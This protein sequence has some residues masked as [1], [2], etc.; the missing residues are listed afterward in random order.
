MRLGFSNGFKIIDQDYNPKNW[1]LLFFGL[2][3][4]VNLFLVGN[5]Y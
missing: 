2:F 5:N 4:L 3:F 1:V